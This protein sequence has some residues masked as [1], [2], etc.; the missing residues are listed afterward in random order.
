MKKVVS[1][2][3]NSV[4]NQNWKPSLQNFNLRRKEPWKEKKSQK[5]S[6]RE[7]SQETGEINQERESLVPIAYKTKTFKISNLLHFIYFFS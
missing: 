2:T 7:K 3:N 1:L 4:F 6:V 5:K